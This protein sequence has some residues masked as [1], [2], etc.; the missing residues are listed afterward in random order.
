MFLRK[1]TVKNKDYLYAVENIWKKGQVK[2]KV[3][4]YL[5]RIVVFKKVRS[6]SFEKFV[7][8]KK[9]I[10]FNEYLDNE[11]CDEMIYDLVR[12]ELF[13]YGFKV[14][15]KIAIKDKCSADFTKRLKIL[16]NNG[17]GFCIKAKEGY[18]NNLSINMLLNADLG[19]EDGDAD[20][21][22]EAFGFA[23]L[24][25]EGG[26]KVPQE[27]FV[28]LFHRKFLVKENNINEEIRY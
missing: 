15:D 5:G 2:Q 1:K 14:S 18:L 26:I 22:K 8:D 17:R 3:K 7:E 20:R 27:V 10:S 11:G 4:K 28:E 25:V 13:K 12:W 9:K 21:K 19:A 16:S 23:R 24:F 6:V